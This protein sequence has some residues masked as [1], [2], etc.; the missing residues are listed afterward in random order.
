MSE[1]VE[2]FN[3]YFLS[4]VE[5]ISLAC[6]KKIISNNIDLLKT[7]ISK[8]KTSIIEFFHYIYLNIKNK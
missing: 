3:T 8:K 5:G 4:L 2:E 6:D 7:I 1:Q